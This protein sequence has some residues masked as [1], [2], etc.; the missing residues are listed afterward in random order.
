MKNPMSNI[1]FLM[2]YYIFSYL[3]SIA[4]KALPQVI[5]SLA[6]SKLGTISAYFTFCTCKPHRIKPLANICCSHLPCILLV[7]KMMSLQS[8][9]SCLT[10]THR[11]LVCYPCCNFPVHAVTIATSSTI[12]WCLYLTYIDR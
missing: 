6:S 9:R 12:I 4:I 8:F 1:G 3:F 11:R 2:L 5:L 7:L 10:P